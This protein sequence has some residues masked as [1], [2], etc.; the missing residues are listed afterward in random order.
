MNPPDVRTCTPAELDRFLQDWVD[1]KADDEEI[2]E[3]D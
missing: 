1:A 3:D 2:D